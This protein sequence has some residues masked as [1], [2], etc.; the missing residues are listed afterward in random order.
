MEEHEFF[1]KKRPEEEKNEEKNFY[2]SENGGEN[3]TSGYSEKGFCAEGAA[4]SG[5]NYALTTYKS[6]LKLSVVSLILCCLGGFGIFFAVP[7]LMRAI[8]LSKETKSETVKWAKVI[9]F[10]SVLLNLV[11]FIV[12][13]VYFAEHYT[14]IELPND[15][16]GSS[17]FSG[18]SAGTSGAALISFLFGSI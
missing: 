15:S 6:A 13:V 4:Y 2:G 3:E 14:P 12:S 7:A 16:S 11:V 9:A 8:S 17:S 10:V 5:N 1:G 18:G